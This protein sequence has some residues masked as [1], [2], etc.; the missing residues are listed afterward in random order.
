MPQFARPLEDQNRDP[1]N[2]AESDVKLAY[3]TDSAPFL[4][5]MSGL[6]LCRQFPHCLNPGIDL[7]LRVKVRKAE[8]HHALFHGLKGF[9]H[10]RRA[11]GAGAG[12][13][14]IGDSQFIAD[15]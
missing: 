9:M 12:G 2:G 6:L 13:D 10:Q 14:S 3:N 4:Y 7:F 8:P 5:H 15:L 1:K 11:V